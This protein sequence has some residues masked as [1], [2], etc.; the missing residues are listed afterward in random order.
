MT[1]IEVSITFTAIIH[2]GE[3]Y[4]YVEDYFTLLYDEELEANEIQ[5]DE[6]EAIANKIG[7]LKLKQ[8]GGTVINREI[9]S[10]DKL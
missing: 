9:T 7:L 2:T 4:R 8:Y 1:D 6:I 5:D 3:K 10:I